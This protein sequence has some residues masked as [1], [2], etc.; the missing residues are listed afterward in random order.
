MSGDASLAKFFIFLLELTRKDLLMGW[1]REPF[2][3]MHS[4]I[5][6]GNIVL[7]K[8][9][10]TRTHDSIKC[11]DVAELVASYFFASILKKIHH[12]TVNSI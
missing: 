12:L 2:Y 11:E 4:I 9:E 3:P 6:K 7:A 10:C 8:R 1:W 5:R